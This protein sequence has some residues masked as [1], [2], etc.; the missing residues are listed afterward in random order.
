MTQSASTKPYSD[1]GEGR[2]EICPKPKHP[3]C[4][5]M[6]VHL[7]GPLGFLNIYRCPHCGSESWT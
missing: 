1:Q 7:G 6:P 5:Q 2:P 4:G 3:K